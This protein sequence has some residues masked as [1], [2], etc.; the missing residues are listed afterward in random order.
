MKTSLISYPPRPAG[1]FRASAPAFPDSGPAFPARPADAD[2][3]G[4]QPIQFVRRIADGESALRRFLRTT[5]RIFTDNQS[6]RELEDLTTQAQLPLTT[7][8]R[9]AVVAGHGGAGSSTIATI[10]ASVYAARRADP[11]LAADADPGEGSL[12]WRLGA[13]DEPQL[14]CLAPKLLAARGGDLRG[15]LSLLPRTLAGLWVLP[16]GAPGQ[17]QLCATVTQAL[18]RVFAVCVTDGAST[19][20]PVSPPA[21]AVLATSHAT[22]LVT[23]ATPD[24]VRATI[25]GLTQTAPAEPEIVPERT[26]VVLN[27]P[28]PHGAAALQTNVAC[29]ELC[30]LGLAVVAV[31]YDR[32][33][34]SGALITPS[35]IAEP[36][37]VAVTRLAGQVL[38]LSRQQWP[39]SRARAAV[40][41]HQ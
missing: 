18:S 11:V 37:L 20:A 40:A 16:S 12:T 38:G 28:Y 3:G 33:L 10:L 32:H 15:F 6:T 4:A 19:I 24:G 23:A 29:R 5:S 17:P 36:T 13:S 31:P 26:V 35:W 1:A 41:R 9:I 8:R 14:G 7:G 27:S 39:A 25:R 22:V 30:Q 21:A 2:D 34:A